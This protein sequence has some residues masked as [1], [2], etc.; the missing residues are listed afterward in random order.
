MGNP[1]QQFALQQIMQRLAAAQAN[2]GAA[3]ASLNTPPTAG[4]GGT[5]TARSV[6]QLLAENRGADPGL[7]LKIVENMMGEAAA[8][9]NASHMR[10]PG[11]AVAMSR[12]LPAIQRAHKEAQQASSTMSAAGGPLKSAPLVNSPI[13]PAPGA[14]PAANT[15][16][17][18]P[19]TTGPL[20][21]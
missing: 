14:G 8:V 19:G 12:V 3:P 6:A 9:I 15:G 18:G 21:G 20:Y 2:R 16:L 4:S 10:F 17:G 13:A 5:N 1:I 11:V 7:I